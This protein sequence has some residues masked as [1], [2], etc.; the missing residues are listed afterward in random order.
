MH[1]RIY[2]FA[3]DKTKIGPSVLKLQPVTEN[4]AALWRDVYNTRMMDVPNS[5]T[6]TTRQVEKMV[7]DNCCYLV[8]DRET[9]VG[10]G[11]VSG[12]KIDAIAS[13]V[14][15]YGEA[16]MCALAGIVDDENVVLE[17]ALENQRAIALYRKMGFVQLELLSEW[18]YVNK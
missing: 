7:Q 12:N 5:V 1:C 6:L 13:C 15:G 17:A 14:P 2:R 10:I 8:Y 9:F 11:K 16:I 18:Y 4:T 3:C